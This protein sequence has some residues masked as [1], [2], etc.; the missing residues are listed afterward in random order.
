M[1]GRLRAAGFAVKLDTNGSRPEILRQFVARRL[2]QAIDMDVKAPLEPERY[3][4]LAGVPV[5]VED[6]R[7]S[8]EVIRR[9]GLPHRFRTTFVPGLLDRAAVARL[10]AAIP[11]GSTYVL[12]GFNP[13]RV[14][15]PALGGVA[16]PAAEE[17]ALLGCGSAA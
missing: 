1:L 10:R 8:I 6:I 15:D 7:A 14:L 11:P 3:G 13:R 12:Q 17:L 9:S 2:V 5:R 4:Q 16:A